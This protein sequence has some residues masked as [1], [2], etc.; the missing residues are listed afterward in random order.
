M[1]CA[2][3]AIVPRVLPQAVVGFILIGGFGFFCRL[4]LKPPPWNHAGREINAVKRSVI[5][6]TADVI[7]KVFSQKTGAFGCSAPAQYSRRRWLTA[8]EDRLCRQRWRKSRKS[9]NSC[10]SRQSRDLSMISFKESR[11]KV[12]NDFKEP[13]R[14]PALLPNLWAAKQM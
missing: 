10:D 4:L 5:E 2:P 6:T 1:R 13:S 14:P 3:I 12:R 9:E 11:N 8:H 7:D